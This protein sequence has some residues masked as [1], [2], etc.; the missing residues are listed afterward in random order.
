MKGFFQ[1]F[2]I[3]TSGIYTENLHHRCY[4][5]C[6]IKL[7]QWVQ[8][9]DQHHLCTRFRH[10]V[11]FTSEGVRAALEMSG[12]SEHEYGEAYKQLEFQAILS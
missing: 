3:T 7:Y 4:T 1:Y 2:K 9:R 5:Y 11:W 12:L 6:F 8:H 10:Y